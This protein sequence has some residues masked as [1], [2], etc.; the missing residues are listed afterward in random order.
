M[1]FK[2]APIKSVKIFGIYLL[3]TWKQW[4]IVFNLKFQASYRYILAILDY[5]PLSQWWS[6]LIF[7]CFNA[8]K[9]R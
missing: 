8:N 5:R 3:Y 2:T 4:H 1:F 9:P 7:F 6:N